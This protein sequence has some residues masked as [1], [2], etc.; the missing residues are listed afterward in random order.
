MAN[1]NKEFWDKQMNDNVIKGPWKDR[2]QNKEQQKKVTED[3]SFVE[4]I[5]ETVMV[6]LIHTMNE[7][8]IDIKD[9]NFS[10][11]IGFINECIKAMLHRELGY[12]HPMTR[13]IQSIVVISE[14]DNK[15]RYSHFDTQRLIGILDNILDESEDGF[16]DE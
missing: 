1:F 8:D 4:N 6:Q 10:L 12:P 9:E 15:T 7:N 2:K 16:E 11:E 5:T 14:D 3:M 13:F